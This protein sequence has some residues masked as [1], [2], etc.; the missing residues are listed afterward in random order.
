MRGDT[1]KQSLTAGEFPDFATDYTLYVSTQKLDG[2]KVIELGK[3]LCNQV[4]MLAL[5]WSSHYR[6]DDHL[7]NN[8]PTLVA[9]T[10]YQIATEDIYLRLSSS[11]VKVAELL[12]T[13]VRP[14]T[15]SVADLVKQGVKELSFILIEG[16]AVLKN[17]KVNSDLSTV[18]PLSMAIDLVT[19]IEDPYTLGAT[20]SESTI[21]LIRLLKDGG[22][23]HPLAAAKVSVP[24]N[25]LRQSSGNPTFAYQVN[26]KL[27]VL[28]QA[29]WVR[30]TFAESLIFHGSRLGIP[31]QILEFNR[32]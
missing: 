19:D 12:E 24:I 13:F 23:I 10:G 32:K 22:A 4:G 18:D 15:F 20:G 31:T 16:S 7:P 25:A 28:D 21:V 2:D 9:Y 26:F 1:S 27:R 30:Q 6:P 5:P 8:Q 17:R 29:R 11:H 3:R 14:I